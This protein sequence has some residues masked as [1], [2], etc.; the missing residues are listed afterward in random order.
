MSFRLAFTPVRSREPRLDPPKSAGCSPA[1]IEGPRA[2]RRL[3]QSKRPA[4][5]TDR[6]VRALPTPR[7]V[8]LAW[9]ILWQ[10]APLRGR[11]A[12]G[13]RAWPTEHSRAR[14][15]RGLRLGAAP[16]EA[17]ARV[18][19]LCPN[20]IDSDTHCR[21][22]VTSPAGGADDVRRS[23]APLYKLADGRRGDRVARTRAASR[24]PPRRGARS[25]APKVPS[26]EG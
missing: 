8:A 25:A 20:P 14:G 22:L 7:K 24:V 10:V 18:P 5:T 6:T 12:A 26:I 15:R 17:I 21:S 1:P 9:S 19:K 3:L 13:S 11:V 16:S 2:A 4:S 23:Q